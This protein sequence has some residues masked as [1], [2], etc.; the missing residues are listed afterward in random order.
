MSANEDATPI[1]TLVGPSNAAIPGRQNR[2][3]RA[4]EGVRMRRSVAVGL[5][6]A[7][8]LALVAVPAAAHT[9]TVAVDSQVSADGTVVVEAATSLVDA[10]VVVHDREDGQLG[11]V[12]GYVP[13]TQNDGYRQGVPVEIDDDAWADWGDNRTVWVVLHREGSGDGFDPD[14]DPIQENTFGTLAAERITLAKDDG[15]T[16]VIA[17]RFE[18]QQTGENAVTVSRVALATD[19][20]VAVRAVTDEGVGRVLGSTSLSAGATTN[21]SVQIDGS[22]FAE[23]GRSVTL[24]AQAY[25]GDGGFEDARQVRAGGTSVRSEFEVERT[26]SIDAT[27]ADEGGTPTGTGNGTDTAAV[28]TPTDE[29]NGTGTTATGTESR[30]V[31]P[32]GTPTATARTDA[33]TATATTGGSG[34]GFGIAAA[35]AGVAVFA[36]SRSLSR[37]PEP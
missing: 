36:L 29:G 2:F 1:V 19:G 35:A 25:A 28:V 8:G 24:V 16:S 11:A 20:H 21:V 17:E 30:V 15:E 27:P 31:T 32:A 3:A 9:N 26:G 12:L 37:R 5:A 7:I 33:A 18:P 13:I 22:V 10:F 14:E 23:R 4:V 34:P 6:L